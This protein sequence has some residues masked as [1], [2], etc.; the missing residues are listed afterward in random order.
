MFKHKKKKVIRNSRPILVT[1]LHRSGSTWAG[2]MLAAAPKVA[3]IHE[4]FNIL[5]RLGVNLRPIKY[6]YPYI[7]EENSEYYESVFDGIIHYK[8]PLVRNIAKIRTV[9]NVAKIIRDQGYF[10]LYRINIYRP[11]IKDPIVFF[12]AEWLYKKFNMN[13]LIMIRHPAAFCSSIKIR[14]WKFDFNILLKQP[15]L[16]DKYLCKFKEEIIEYAV[17]EKNLID[18][19]IL[20]WNCFYYTTYIYREKYPEWLFVRHED[21]SL[22]PLNQFQSIFEA[23]GLEFTRKAKAK[24]QKSSGTHNPVEQQAGKEYMR[25]S[26][27]NINNWKNR[28][29][30]N[31]IELIRMKTFEVSSL[32]YTE[33][34]W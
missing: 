11:L 33:E 9:K 10:M 23:F 21:L 18:Q 31:E 19:A 14:N 34:E 15:L 20:L 28:L 32:F 7:C 2:K 22:A 3:Y 13:V 27:E 17:N 26:R 24:I 29:T 1:G 8:Y 25:N 16:M 12:N 4:P 5:I 30:E 6:W